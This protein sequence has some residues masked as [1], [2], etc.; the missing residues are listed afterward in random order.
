MSPL[1]PP[2]PFRHDIATEDIVDRLRALHHLRSVPMH[3]DGGRPRQG[4]EVARGGVLVR[5]RC[6]GSPRRRP[7]RRRGATRPATITSN[8]QLMPTTSASCVA[9]RVGAARHDGRPAVVLDQAVGQ[10]HLRRV[11]LDPVVARSAGSAPSRSA[12]WPDGCPCRRAT[13]VRARPPT[14]CLPSR[15][16][17]VGDRRAATWPPRR[18]TPRSSA[19]ARRRAVRMPRVVARPVGSRGEANPPPDVDLAW[20][21]AVPRG[22]ERADRVGEARRHRPP[23]VDRVVV[24]AE[25]RHHAGHVQLLGSE[26]LGARPPAGPRSGSPACTPTPRAGSARRSPRTR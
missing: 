15:R 16:R 21:P 6:P 13:H 26:R 14:G 24:P 10:E 2:Q 11:Q 5:A 4:V 7:A 3:Q 23:D 9:G 17:G 20:R 18:R 8:P 1:D 19:S 25:V 22:R 12:R